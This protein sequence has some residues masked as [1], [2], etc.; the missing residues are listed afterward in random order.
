MAN[1]KCFKKIKTLLHI[2]KG[3]NDETQMYYK[4]K[5]YKLYLELVR[6]N[7]YDT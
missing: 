5:F 7:I 6:K 2:Y 1:G 3:I 4:L